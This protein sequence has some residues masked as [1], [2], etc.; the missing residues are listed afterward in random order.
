MK[1]D[2]KTGTVTASFPEFQEILTDA[3]RFRILLQGTK[4]S[5]KLTFGRDMSEAE[6]TEFVDGLDA[7]GK[8]LSA[9]L[10]EKIEVADM[11]RDFVQAESEAAIAKASRKAQ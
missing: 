5:F 8:R 11:M 7:K 6:V 3:I 2:D 1:Y 9:I 10:A 4:Q